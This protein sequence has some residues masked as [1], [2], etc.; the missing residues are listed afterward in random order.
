MIAD[1]F[2]RAGMAVR[3]QAWNDKNLDYEIETLN[4]SHLLNICDLAW[5]DKNLDYEIETHC[6]HFIGKGLA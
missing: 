3:E 5:N 6:Y 2:N 4:L 1:S